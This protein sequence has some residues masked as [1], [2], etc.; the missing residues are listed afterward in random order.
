MG[1]VSKAF[2]K[3]QQDEHLFFESIERKTA[4]KMQRPPSK[5]QAKSG[6]KAPSPAADPGGNIIASHWDERLST[7]TDQKSPIAETF[8][9]LRSKILHPP[10]KTTPPRTI[11][12]TSVS[13]GEGKGFV[14]ANLGIAL[15]RG[16]SHHA[17]LVDCDLRKPSLAGLFGQFD[18]RGLSDYLQN[19]AKLP[20]LI[21]KTGM[22]KLSFIAGGPPP[23]NP[24]ELLDSKKMIVLIREL[25]SRYDDRF[26]LFDTPPSVVASETRVLA[27]YVDGVIVVVRWGESDRQEVKQLIETIGRDKILGIVFNAYEVNQLEKFMT[28]RKLYGKYS[29]YYS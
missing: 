4:D 29:G 15:A 12:L 10:T 6:I 20:D 5:P 21:R 17:L 28:K 11:L 22:P 25:A 16:M 18:D 27:Q 7:T 3:A 26:I 23:G 24:A 13:P 19:N 2:K 9:R 1:K 8:N 14:C